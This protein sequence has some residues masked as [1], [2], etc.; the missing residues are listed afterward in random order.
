MESVDHRDEAL[1]YQAFISYSHEDRRWARWLMRRLERYRVPRRLVGTLGEH[2]EIP[3]SLA[4][5][6]RDREELPSGADLGRHVEEALADSEAMILIA[7]PA[8]ARS[9]WVNQEIRRFQSFGRGDRIL[10]FVVDGD[11]ADLT[12]SSGC[13]APAL[14]YDLDE[15]GR[16]QGEPRE[17]IAAD[18]RDQGDGR[19]RAVGKLVAGLLG[20]GYGDLQQRELQRRQQRLLAVTAGLVAGLVLT[21]GL[22]ISAYLAREDAER[23]RGQAENLLGFMVGDLRESLEPLGRLDLLEKVG[24]EAMDYFSTVEPGDLS[25]EG[26]ARQAQTLTQIG[27]I[28]LSQARYDEALAS[29]QQALVRSRELVQRDPRNGDRLYD[30]GQAEFWVGYVPYEA[31]DPAAAQPWFEAYLETS[32]ALV[33]LDPDRQDWR[34]EL[35]YAQHNL[36]TLELEE[37]RVDR[38]AAVFDELTA[39]W[40]SLDCDDPACDEI[41]FDLADAYTWQGLAALRRGRLVEFE[42]A[43]AQARSTYAALRRSEPAN[44]QFDAEYAD[45]TNDLARAAYFLG[46]APEAAA[47]NA[48]AIALRRELMEHD[49]DNREWA[50]GYLT[51][52]VD[53]A[54][55]ALAFGQL[56]EGADFLANLEVLA[57]AF[58]PPNEPTDASASALAR[59]RLLEARYLAGNLSVAEERLRRARAHLEQVRSSR[60]SLALAMDALEA[61][62]CR[63]RERDVC[64]PT[65]EE[66]L[67]ALEAEMSS[68]LDPRLT[69]TWV[70][71][72]TDESLVP[73][74]S[75]EQQALLDALRRGGLRHPAL[76]S[77]GFMPD[78][79]EEATP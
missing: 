49:P 73:R 60:S 14:L 71:L 39:T 10:A 56:E 29:F 18:A 76:W 16:P 40:E 9:R 67:R 65:V 21:G 54:E 37:G 75:P 44:R 12:G 3:R 58:L 33:A 22:A 6:F 23:R 24:N 46:K 68:N 28:R 69:V 5:L 53:Q 66:I 51:S 43:I 31:G 79:K 42:R 59:A 63:V 38:A 27:R 48:E 50:D 19:K 57:P 26:L 77:K 78:N 25:D 72:V 30:R 36:A 2:G 61:E 8:S 34:I 1:K 35:A 13:F 11:P 52:L 62:L 32:Q 4:P 70:S 64:R 55:F 7:S 45:E 20:I 15:E 47:L 17:P 41:K 74:R